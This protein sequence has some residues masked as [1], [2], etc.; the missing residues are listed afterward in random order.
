M[1]IFKPL[2]NKPKGAGM[3]WILDHPEFVVCQVQADRLTK[4]ELPLKCNLHPGSDTI[5]AIDMP[6]RKLTYRILEICCESFR[7]DIDQELIKI[8]KDR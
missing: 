6:G 2:L 7:Q 3:G 5:I 4:R 8:K 1:I